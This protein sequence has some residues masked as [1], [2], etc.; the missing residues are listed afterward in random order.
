[1]T[2]A[3][4]R[5]MYEQASAED[6]H[7]AYKDVDPADTD[8]FDTDNTPLHLACAH[9]DS[10]AVGIL[11]SKDANPNTPNKFG[12]MP[13][14]ILAEARVKS[15]S[16][17]AEGEIR[18]CAELL[19]EARASVLRKDEQ[20]RTPILAAGRRGNHELLEAAVEKGVKLTLT[21][22]NGN[23]ALHLVCRW[24]ANELESLEYAQAKADRLDTNKLEQLKAEADKKNEDTFSRIMY[25]NELKRH[26]ETRTELDAQQAVVEGFY[27]SAKA[28]LEGGLDP[29]E[30]NNAGKTPLEL[31]IES[32]DKRIGALL[33]GI[34]PDQES[35]EALSGGMTLHQAV[36]QGDHKAI[37]ACISLG[38]DL[39]AL[40]DEEGEY[41]GM[42][43]LAAACRLFDLEAVQLLL[44]AGADPNFKDAE[45]RTALAW[46]FA[47]QGDR[48]LTMRAADGKVPQKILKAMLDK[49]AAIDDAIDDKS[50]TMLTSACA[51]AHWGSR[52]NGNP[53][54]SV[55][56]AQ[57][58]ILAR[59]DVNKANGDGQTPLMFICQCA[60][61]GREVSE[62]QISLLEAD[63]AVDAVDRN[64]NTPLHYAAGNPEAG[65]GREMAEM[66]FEF[67]NPNPE[68]VNNEGKTALEIATDN[69]NEP[70]VKLILMNS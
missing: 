40:C 10:I 9:A 14:H 53:V 15:R 21:D 44:E 48:H 1:M 68:A 26:T 61:G 34:D 18:K 41:K 8:R 17:I 30:K 69:N 54:L 24:V 37:E 25:Q 50:N 57:T 5:K 33:Q 2:T 60:R 28:L 55:S 6:I 65:T 11:L 47:W 31:A 67:G 52:Y 12:F 23:T 16:A 27:R 3:E 64:G 29:T 49:G 63:A 7:A 22:G 70:L 58:L 39:N 19:F 51:T 20:G 43:P 56:A 35:P 46:W 13:L 42:T 32:C 66:L 45:G 59:T 36:G 62:L 4:I 38:A